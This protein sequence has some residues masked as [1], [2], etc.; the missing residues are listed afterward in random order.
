MSVR[1]AA[2]RVTALALAGLALAAMACV[3]R[4][5]GAKL[6]RK[7]CSACHGHAGAGNFPKYSRYPHVNLVDDH[8]SDEAE[9][10]QL[11]GI[12][13]SGVFPVMPAFD[14][15]SDHE[16]RAILDHLRELRG[17]NY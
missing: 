5:E 16:I 15:L 10:S 3:E 9:P 2:I 6:W 17:E 4:S 7:H 12:I 8:W 14:N 1:R 13:L 11:E